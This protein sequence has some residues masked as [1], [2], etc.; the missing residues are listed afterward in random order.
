MK[1]R[2]LFITITVSLFL[3]GQIFAQGSTVSGTVTS[4]DNNNP[5]IGVNIVVKNT[6]M[7][8]TTDAEGNYV[9]EG[10]AGDAVLVFSYIGL[11]KKKFQLMGDQKLML[12]YHPKRLQVKM[13]L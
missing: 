8:T 2:T 6:N 5:L 10:I 4:A 11:L 13:S 9:L 12:P 7:G 3:V 1:R